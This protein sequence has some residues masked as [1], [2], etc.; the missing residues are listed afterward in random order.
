MANLIITTVPLGLRIL[1]DSTD[2]ILNEFS[3]K[4][5]NLNTDE[6]E[7]ISDIKDN[8][9]D[10]KI[11]L[12]SYTAVSFNGTVITNIDDLVRL[13][14]S[15]PSN[16]SPVGYDEMTGVPIVVEYPHH[17]IHEGD[18]FFIMYSVASLGALSSPD[19]TMTLTFKTPNSLKYIHFIFSAFGSADW[20]VRLIES[21]T[22]G[23]TDATGQLTILNHNRNSLK[24]ST[25]SDGTT[26]NQVNYDALLATGGVT[27]WDQYLEGSGG[28]QSAGSGM[29]KRNELILKANTT[30][31][32]SMY[33]T[34]TNPGTLIMDW[35]EHTSL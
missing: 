12:S 21:P 34:D 13:L 23:A 27:L 20:R 11:N 19:D 7:I 31:Q 14:E 2:F 18:G 8:Y 33:G 28:P 6:L 32:L 17:E 24:T 29:G 1:T 5:N 30:Y 4:R 35:Y 16:I 15:I 9:A 26:A 22:G 10:F 25:V 3:L